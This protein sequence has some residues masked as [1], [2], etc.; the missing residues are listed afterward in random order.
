MIIDDQFIRSFHN[1]IYGSNFQEHPKEK[2]D[3]LRTIQIY[4]QQLE[5]ADILVEIFLS[6]KWG[7]KVH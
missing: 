1:K 3:R 5:V 6:M 7:Y 4:L 2:M